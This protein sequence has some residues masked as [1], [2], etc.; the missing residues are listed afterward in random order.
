MSG[1]GSVAGT[2]EAVR[3]D[4]PVRRNGRFL[5][6]WFGHATSA[7]GDQVSALA[8][9]LIAATTLHAGP[10]QL[11]LLT[12]VLW[13]PQLLSLLVGTGVDRLHRVRPPLIVANLV[14]CLAVAVVPVAAV[15][16]ALSM[17]L[18]YAVGLVLGVGEVL[19]GTSY[20]RFFVRVVPRAQYVAANSLLSTT[21]SAS[22]IAGP[23]LGGALI[24][25]LTAP[26]AM[27]ADALTFLVSAAAI[28]SV[29]VDPADGAA[30]EPY[31]LRLRSGVR[32]LRG[33]R[34]LRA[35]LGCST[36]MNLAAFMVQA[37]LVLYATRELRL[38]AGQIGVALGVGA[39]GG[40]V[41]ATVAGRIARLIGTGRT[42][43]AGAVLY[44]LP[45]AGLALATPGHPGMVVL[46]SVEALSGFGVMLFDINNNAMRAAATRDDMR[47]RV[48]GAYSTVNY[49][50]RPLGA[51]V[52]G[53]VAAR[54]GI[55]PVL[56]AAALLGSL[57]LLW[58]AA[59]PVIR[60]R[61][62]T[63]LVP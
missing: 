50:V 63:D 5:R 43:A 41:G 11:G 29:P 45:S 54:T 28:R 47:A 7:F 52:G 9:P 18:L 36:T 14:Q 46:A 17:P 56:V 58:L 30:A 4:Q 25:L 60:L 10:G 34:Y 2:A 51:L 61:T 22:N 32:Y 24:Q 42:I 3:A 15:F 27:L 19:Y 31:L 49:G 55:T 53:V 59:S 39:V 12:A 21:T 44:C 33:H 1:H 62:V 13:T 57:S 40:L 26:V 8:M 16:G 35:S 20:P 23:A 48:S 38:G 6:Y 37:L